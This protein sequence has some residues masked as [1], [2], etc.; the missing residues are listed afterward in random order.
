VILEGSFSKVSVSFAS[1]WDFFKSFRV[2][3][4]LVV[5]EVD[6]EAI[7]GIQ[8]KRMQKNIA[9]ANKLVGW[10]VICRF[11]PALRHD[12]QIY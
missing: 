2:G 5:A 12:N 1:S 8:Q 11:Y 7:V 6:S 3:L 9:L 4:G 10:S